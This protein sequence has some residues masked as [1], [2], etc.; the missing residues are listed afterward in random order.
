MFN[1]FIKFSFCWRYET[2]CTRAQLALDGFVKF[3][4][5]L[6]SRISHPEYLQAKI[7]RLSWDNV[8]IYICHL[9]CQIL[10]KRYLVY[11]LHEYVY[12][13]YLVSDQIDRRDIQ[14]FTVILLLQLN[15]NFKG[16]V[17]IASHQYIND[18]VPTGAI[19]FCNLSNGIRNV[20]S[21]AN[22][23]DVSSFQWP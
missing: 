3:P 11:N 5:T 8:I 22:K 4:R 23:S 1:K 15:H 20:C 9:R 14:V 18:Q 2:L 6:V 12:F 7:I 16:H 21:Q 19:Q 13:S 17:K 10:L